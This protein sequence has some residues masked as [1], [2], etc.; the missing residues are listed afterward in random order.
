MWTIESL[1][2]LLDIDD[3]TFA[4]K[5]GAA[6]G[7]HRDTLDLAH[8]RWAAASAITGLDL[9]AA[10]LGRHWGAQV[11]A[12]KELSV[13]ELGPNGHEKKVRYKVLPP[14]ARKWVRDV[15]KDTDYRMT[16][17]VRNPFVHGMMPR[18]LARIIGAPDYSQPRVSLPVWGAPKDP[19]D[20]AE[21]MRTMPVSARE[22]IERI[23]KMA[24]DH[25]ELFV[26][27]V[28]AAEL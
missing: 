17:A 14:P 9:C 2:Y 3:A 25:A 20:P 10:A 27:G 1:Y 28:V 15:L 4:A 5:P 24:T 7:Y 18:S 6:R 13:V 12:D 8:V 26:A 21:V 22:L 19:N 11:D 16:K 23:I